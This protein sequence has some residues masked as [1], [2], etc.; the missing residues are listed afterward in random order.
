MKQTGT[1]K[2]LKKDGFE[3]NYRRVKLLHPDKSKDGSFTCVSSL[4]VH[5][6][7]KNDTIYDTVNL[8]EKEVGSKIKKTIK[9]VKEPVLLR[10]IV[11]LHNI[12]GIK[13]KN[14]IRTMVKMI[15][16]LQV[17]YQILN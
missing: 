13:S 12:N 8:F 14:Q 2:K 15:F 11:N 3:W 6:E 1:K 10:D 4:K 7:N 9:Q 5:L 16:Y 17:D